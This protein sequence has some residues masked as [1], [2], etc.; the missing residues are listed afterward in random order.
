MKFEKEGV[1][2][3]INV[4]QGDSKGN[5]AVNN[6]HLTDETLELIR[7]KEG[8]K[9]V[10]TDHFL[11]GYAKGVAVTF[12]SAPTDIGGATKNID[13]YLNNKSFSR[14]ALI[15]LVTPIPPPLLTKKSCLR[16]SSN[17]FSTFSLI[18]CKGICPGPSIMT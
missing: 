6:S 12:P 15:S 7:N 10:L 18:I 13:I 11:N 14:I 9:E 4:I 17:S 3:S 1:T 5:K 16:N 8:A 2:Y